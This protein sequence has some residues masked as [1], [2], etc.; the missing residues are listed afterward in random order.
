MAQIVGEIQDVPL[1]IAETVGL[2]RNH[3]L[4]HKAFYAN[5]SEQDR[6][7][8]FRGEPINRIFNDNNHIICENCAQI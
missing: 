1:M 5:V 6:S 4:L 8:I 2:A 3:R 7:E